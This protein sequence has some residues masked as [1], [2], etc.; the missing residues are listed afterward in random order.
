MT[1]TLFQSKTFWFSLAT[2]L[3][4]AMQAAQTLNLDATTMGY[5]TTGI[6]VVSFVLRLLTNSAISSDRG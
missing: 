6:G 1:K 4:G 2:I 3:L 5:I